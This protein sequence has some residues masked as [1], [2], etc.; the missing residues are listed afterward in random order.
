M[1]LSWVWFRGHS[2]KTNTATAAKNGKLGSS[3][4]AHRWDCFLQ[5][6]EKVVFGACGQPQ[7]HSIAVCAHD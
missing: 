2:Q 6:N 5:G 3:V 1:L 4:L 7:N